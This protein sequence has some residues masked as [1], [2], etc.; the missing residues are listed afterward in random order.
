MNFSYL[1][2]LLESTFDMVCLKP[3]ILFLMYNRDFKNVLTESCYELSF[4]KCY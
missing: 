1:Y 4:F 3:N 2:F